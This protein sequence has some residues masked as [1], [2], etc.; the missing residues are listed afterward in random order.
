VKIHPTALV[1]PGAELAEDV[2]VGPYAIIEADVT[3]GAGS[4]I[5]PF[6]YLAAGARL[7][8][9]VQVY[10]GAVIGTN[11]QDLKFQG[12]PS[13]AEIGEGTILREYVTVHRGTEATGRTIVGSNCFLMAY[14]HVA[15]DCVIGDKVIMANSVNLGG[16]VHIEEQASVGGLVPVHQFVRIG[17]HS[18]I[19][20]GFRT[21]QDVPPYILAGEVPLRYIGLNIIG[22][23]RRGFSV[24]T[25][26]ALKQAY[27]L[28]YLS[29][30][31]VTQGISR[32]REEM[33]IIPEVQ[34]VIDFI[35]HSK[36]GII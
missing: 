24:G 26:D 3:V 6:A 9:R 1:N 13:T 15:H 30:L 19:G 34:R 36:R 8:N 12:E 22:L 23:K 5:G 32:I 28:I 16:H 14:S 17:C 11:P 2:E 20:G 29:D 31:N 7:G 25:L 35:E 4:K 18:F 27:K 33:E 10:N 21:V